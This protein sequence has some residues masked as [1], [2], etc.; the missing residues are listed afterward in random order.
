VLSAG[1]PTGGANQWACT[2]ARRIFSGD[3][4]EYLVKMDWG[5]LVVRR[6]PADRFAEGEMAVLTLDPSHCVVINR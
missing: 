5:Q 6:P 4:V 1:A 2:I 3:F